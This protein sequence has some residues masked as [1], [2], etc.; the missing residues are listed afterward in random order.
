MSA[1]LVFVVPDAV[2][3]GSGTVPH[4]GAEAVAL[5]QLRSLLL[6]R[7]RISTTASKS[8]IRVHAALPMMTGRSAPH[9]GVEQ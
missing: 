7:R 2:T 4:M 8:S 6:N 5:K 1:T 9:E 3:T